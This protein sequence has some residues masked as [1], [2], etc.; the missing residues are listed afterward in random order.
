MALWEHVCIAEGNTSGAH[1]R[2]MCA[3]MFLT[4]SSGICLAD[5]MVENL[6]R[7]KHILM[8]GGP[9]AGLA[10]PARIEIKMLNSNANARFDIRIV[11]FKL[12]AFFSM[13]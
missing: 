8:A 12:G 1:V 11:E 5:G 7:Q 13:L 4:L 3:A 6:M 9:S 2:Q 10:M